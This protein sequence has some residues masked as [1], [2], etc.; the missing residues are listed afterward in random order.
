M[1]WTKLV[2]GRRVTL[3]LDLSF[4][5]CSCDRCC[6]CCRPS[7]N[8]ALTLHDP[9]RSGKHIQ[10]D[11]PPLPEP[12]L[13]IKICS[14]TL[15]ARG[16]L[17][18]PP[19]SSNFQQTFLYSSKYHEEAWHSSKTLG[20]SLFTEPINCYVHELSFLGFCRSRFLP[21]ADCRH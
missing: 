18:D 6:P 21:I 7:Q 19:T 2:P 9:G 4:T 10:S 1:I 20:A 14:L 16:V 8:L 5:K 13:F 15:G 11:P 17:C 3:F 12:T